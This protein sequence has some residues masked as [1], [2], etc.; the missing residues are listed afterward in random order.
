MVMRKKSRKKSRKKYNSGKK[1]IISLLVVV[2]IFFI[3]FSASQYIFP[4]HQ[5][6]EFIHSEIIN[7]STFDR[8]TICA[9]N[10]AMENR[11]HPYFN[12]NK[13]LT[14]KGGINLNNPLTTNVNIAVVPFLWFEPS[15]CLSD[16]I[17]STLREN[18]N[19][20][21][22][23]KA[24]NIQTQEYDNVFD[25]TL[26]PFDTI[27]DGHSRVEYW[28]FNLQ[29]E[30]YSFYRNDTIDNISVN[31]YFCKENFPA[32]RLPQGNSLCY[33]DG[34]T[35][36]WK[37][38]NDDIYYKAFFEAPVFELSSEYINNGE[39]F[40]EYYHTSNA[41]YGNFFTPMARLITGNYS[42]VGEYVIPVNDTGSGGSG[43]SGGGSSYVYEEE[44]EVIVTQEAP[45]EVAPITEQVFVKIKDYGGY[46]ILG[47]LVFALIFFIIR[48]NKKGNKKR[49]K[50]RK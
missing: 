42:I 24:L 31:Y 30:D 16:V 45:V 44:E 46:I 29:G 20:T 40:I 23:I 19:G 7:F 49:N 32:S 37:T 6:N 10:G 50:R 43:G 28:W 1:I 2:S 21:I 4:Q 5:D 36:Y 34:S 14:I 25:Y 12:S 18:I 47:I 27:I 11:L 41:L 22:N 17:Y 8:Q 33:T 26:K 35:E 9:G 38:V 39:I 15:Y 13:L 3:L 48:N